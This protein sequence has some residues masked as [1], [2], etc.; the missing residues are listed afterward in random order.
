MGTWRKQNFSAAG[1]SERNSSRA[2]PAV[3][4]ERRS[5][6]LHRCDVGGWEAAGHSRPPTQGT[7]AAC[8]RAGGRGGEYT[9]AWRHGAA[10]AYLFQQHTANSAAV[11][12]P[13]RQRRAAQ[14]PLVPPLNNPHGRTGM[15]GGDRG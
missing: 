4:A 6:A 5:H 7:H 2:H 8:V 1:K 11:A 12:F 14:R 9:A 13:C 15:M 10:T 3:L